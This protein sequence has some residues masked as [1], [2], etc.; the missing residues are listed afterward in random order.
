[1]IAILAGIVGSVTAAF[2]AVTTTMLAGPSAVDDEEDAFAAMLEED[3]PPV[4][5]HDAHGFFAPERE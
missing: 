1:M 2:V 5:G 3:I 4:T